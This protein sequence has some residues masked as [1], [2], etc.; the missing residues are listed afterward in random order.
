MFAAKP[1]LHSHPVQTQA[2]LHSSSAALRSMCLSLLL[3]CIC[4]VLISVCLNLNQVVFYVPALLH[5]AQYGPKEGGVSVDGER[6]TVT[7]RLAAV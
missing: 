3:L 4:F 6:Q 5:L 2:F 7:S 1:A